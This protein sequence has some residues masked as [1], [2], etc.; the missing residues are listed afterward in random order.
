M[1]KSA[2]L[3]QDW[4][5]GIVSHFHDHH[6]LVSAVITAV[7]AAR[8]AGVPVI[9]VRVAFSEGYHEISPRNRTFAAAS[10][11]GGLTVIHSATQI[12]ASVQPHDNEPIVTKHRVSA[13]SGSNLDVNLRAKDIDTLIL[14]GIAT[15]GVV[16]STVREAA[17]KDF[18]I[19][20]LSD[21]CADPDPA[22]HHLLMEKVFPRQAEVLTTRRTE[23]AK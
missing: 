23:R 11:Q 13:F 16:L 2:L 6:H 12:H 21:A 4:Q 7:P 19:T 20:V 22:V 5:N 14:T 9:F 15:S 18:R 10:Q 17:D 1:S 3:V 8:G